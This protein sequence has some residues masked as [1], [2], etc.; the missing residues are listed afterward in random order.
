MVCCHI[1]EIDSLHDHEVWELVEIPEGQKLVGNK[2]IFKVKRNT[3]GSI[4]RCK[5]RLVVPECSQR[6]GLDYDET[7]SPVV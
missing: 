1:A 5:A 4:E 2:W 7:F 6:E 3:D